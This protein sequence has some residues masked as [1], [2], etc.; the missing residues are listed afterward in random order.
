VVLIPLII[1]PSTNETLILCCGYRCPEQ[2]LMKT[3]PWQALC[4]LE[5]LTASANHRLRAALRR[6]YDV[7]R[8]GNAARMLL[9]AGK[10]PITYAFIKAL[11]RCL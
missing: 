8:S 10:R 7:A 2:R 4:R 3:I 5:Y 1:G 9:D 6:I 11:P